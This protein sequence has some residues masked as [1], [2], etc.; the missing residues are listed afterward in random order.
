M[1]LSN[2]LFYRE[3][4]RTRSARAIINQEIYNTG[5]LLLKSRGRMEQCFSYDLKREMEDGLQWPGLSDK[6]SIH[7]TTGLVSKLDTHLHKIR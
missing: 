1:Q 2:T 4:G 6:V 5:M 7:N 3:P